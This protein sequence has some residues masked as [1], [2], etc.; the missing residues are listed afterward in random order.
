MNNKIFITL[1][2]VLVIGFLAF[3]L[4]RGNTSSNDEVSNN[5]YGNGSA[6]VVMIEAYS[7][8]CPACT[9]YHPL[10]KEIREEFKD[11]IKFQVMHFPLTASFGA[12]ARI[13]HRAVEAAALQGQDKFWAL[14]DYIFENREDWWQGGNADADAIY[15][16][17]V[18]YATELGLNIEKFEEDYDSSSV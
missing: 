10:L 8:A 9:E 13:P 12:N 2:S 5:F 1:I 16:K 4:T 17:M 11:Q 18:E 6:E 7:L 3:A 14:H 15:D